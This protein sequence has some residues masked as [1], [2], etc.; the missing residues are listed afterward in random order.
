MVVMGIILAD[1]IEELLM[2]PSKHPK[3]PLNSPRNKV[4]TILTE[5]LWPGSKEMGSA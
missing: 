4:K 3:H 2:A 5:R 1:V